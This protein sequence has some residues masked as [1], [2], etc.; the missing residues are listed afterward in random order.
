M[1]KRLPVLPDRGDGDSKEASSS[2]GSVDRK[3][4]IGNVALVTLGCSKNTVDSELMLGALVA[5]GFR[6][7]EDPA[8]ADLIVVNTC[9]FI[10][11]AV[12]ESIDVILSLVSYKKKGRCRKLVVVGCMVER[13]KRDLAM[14]LPEVDRFVSA[15]E[16]LR[17]GFEEGTT[18]ECFDQA[19]RPY[20]LYDESMPRVY[21]TGRGSAYVKISDGC[22]RK[23]TFCIIPD[24]RG[25]FRSRSRDSIVS[26]VRTMVQGGVREINLV[27][28]DLTAYGTDFSERPPAGR[29]LVSLLREITRTLGHAQDYWIRLYYA[30]PV[31]TTDE[32][33]RFVADTPFLCNYLD[34]PLQHISAAVLKRMQRPLGE[35]G[36]RELINRIRQTAPGIAL[37]TTFLVGFPGET[38]RDVEQLEEFVRA[39]HFAHVGVFTYSQERE[40]KSYAYPAQVE[41]AVKEERRSRIMLAQRDIVELRLKQFVNRQVRILVDRQQ[42]ATTFVG[43]TEWQGPEEDGEVFVSA[44]K[45][46]QIGQ[47]AEVE[48]TGAR[49]YDLIAKT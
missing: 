33:I 15:D 21:S 19:R 32:L 4:F 28:Q 39:G 48:I 45:K 34:I 5:R 20:F 6:S 13:Y 10:E 18:A 22:D 30:Y 1:K 3:P 29:E 23:C 17:I 16:I 2:L 14:E 25:S 27:A 35:K 12:K 11:S 47:F 38:D 7:V 43:R 37:R 40:A 31:G 42:D 26:E 41:E 36:S 24:I 46:M 8:N 44:S 9:A 49:S